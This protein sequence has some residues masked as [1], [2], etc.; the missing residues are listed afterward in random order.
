M[1]HHRRNR[2]D[3]SVVG[4]EAIHPTVTAF[5]LLSFFRFSRFLT[6]QEVSAGLCGSCHFSLSGRLSYRAGHGE[7]SSPHP[8]RPAGSQPSRRVT[9]CPD[10]RH[11]GDDRRHFDVGFK[12]RDNPDHAANRTGDSRACRLPRVRHQERLWH[13]ADAHDC[14]WGFYRWRGNPGRNTTKYDFY[15]GLQ[16]DSFP[17]LRPSS[18]PSGCCSV[19]PPL[20]CSLLVTW[21]YLTF[22]VFPYHAEGMAGGSRFLRTRLHA[23]GPMSARGEKSRSSRLR[24]RCYGSSERICRSEV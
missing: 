2:A 16:Q 4:I 8:H 21:A 15:R 5:C 12:H 10:P 14:L 6:P 13:R 22:F 9:T 3:R 19:S 1:A 18:F 20:S 24:R 23:L 11:H 17:T 7:M